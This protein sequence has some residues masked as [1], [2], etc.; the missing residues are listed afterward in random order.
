MKAGVGHS[1]L[2]LDPTADCDGDQAHLAQTESDGSFEI[3]DVADGSYAL[4]NGV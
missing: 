1:Y 3:N 2:V 4:K